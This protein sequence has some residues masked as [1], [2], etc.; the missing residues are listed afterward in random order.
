ML[1]NIPKKFYGKD[2]I[3]KITRVPERILSSKKS[4]KPIMNER[5]NEKL[6]GSDTVL[7]NDL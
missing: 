4:I 2:G 3:I 7:L 6:L 5:C 1:I